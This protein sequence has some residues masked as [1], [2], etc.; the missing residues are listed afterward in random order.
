MAT[1]DH[2]LHD[3]RSTVFKE[4]F[5]T[6]PVQSFAEDDRWDEDLLDASFAEDSPLL[7][8]PGKSL[9]GV[10]ALP[11]HPSFSGELPVSLSAGPDNVSR[12]D[13]TVIP[14]PTQ[15]QP[16]QRSISRPV[17]SNITNGRPTRHPEV[18][19]TRLLSARHA[20]TPPPPRTPFTSQVLESSRLRV[21]STSAH[22]RQASE[23][24]PLSNFRTPAPQ[25]GQGK[26]VPGSVATAEP[27]A[28]WAGR[29]S[30][31]LDR[32]RRQDLAAAFPGPGVTVN[33]SETD[34]LYA[35]ATK[36]SRIR[37]ALEHLYSLCVN[38]AARDSFVVFQLQYAT[39]HNNTELSKPIKLGKPK[40]LVGR[41]D[42]ETASAGSAKTSGS[43]M[44]SSSARR[45]LSFIDRLLHGGKS[46][47]NSVA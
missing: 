1:V 13:G 43:S 31:L 15:L 14:S 39:L 11:R 36:T 25:H 41:D 34:K 46:K 47:R 21:V 38:D 37:Q 16:M 28:Y 3:G 2:R 19:P 33:R 45:K 27:S 8:M 17:L 5:T 30:A 29:L 24:S 7:K 32:Y 23:A 6:S 12:E 26:P 18:K 22:L 42:A 4:N 20:P 44:P 9:D 35:A 40:S 10:T